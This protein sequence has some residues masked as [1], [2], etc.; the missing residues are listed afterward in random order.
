VARLAFDP[1]SRKIACSGGAGSR[2]RRF[3]PTA[4]SRWLVP[5]ELFER[6]REALLVAG[7]QIDLEVRL[8]PGLEWAIRQP[9]LAARGFG[10]RRNPRG[11]R[12][13]TRCLRTL[14]CLGC[15]R[16]DNASVRLWDTRGRLRASLCTRRLGAAVRA[17]CRH[18]QQHGERGGSRAHP[19]PGRTSLGHGAPRTSPASG[20]RVGTAMY[21]IGSS[22][23][24]E[25]SQVT[26][27]RTSPSSS[28]RPS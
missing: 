22:P 17:H 10:S 8:H 11:A 26:I 2:C 4:E 13:R 5:G 3:G 16:R 24:S 19:N 25:P 6:I 28:S 12:A 21:D 14:G 15:S 1:H 27:E 7:L 20:G 23:V 18:D 9:R